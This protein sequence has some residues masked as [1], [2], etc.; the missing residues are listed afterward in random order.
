M[1]KAW[2]TAVILLTGFAAIGCSQDDGT[3]SDNVGTEPLFLFKDPATAG[4]RLD[5]YE[6]EGRA[7]ISVGGPMG[8]EARIAQVSGLESLA[9]LYRV[10]HPDIT[11]IPKELIGLTERVISE[12]AELDGSPRPAVKTAE[13]AKD[14]RPFDDAVCR[15][16]ASSSA[17][18]TPVDCR[19]DPNISYLVV[20]GQQINDLV[21][22]DRVYVWNNNPR[23][24]TLEHRLVGGFLYASLAVPQ[25]WW[26]YMTITRD[27]PYMTADV[28]PAGSVR[29]E[30]GLTH[31]VYAPV[32]H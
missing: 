20:G 8:T 28:V 27:G 21:R 12:R 32:I 26:T 1:M 9:E 18:Y 15:T 2:K 25:Y 30:L 7:A 3:Q 6:I 31:H 13:I 11:E 17:R 16:F 4:P 5:V 10:I 29:G 24:A 23:T 14:E 22:N 19:W